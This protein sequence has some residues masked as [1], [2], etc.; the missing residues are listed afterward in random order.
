[1]SSLE[2]QSGGNQSKS[3]CSIGK[4]VTSNRDQTEVRFFIS[5]KDEL[6]QTTPVKICILGGEYENICSGGLEST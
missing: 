3:H 4:Q 2:L 6:V 1:M 5:N